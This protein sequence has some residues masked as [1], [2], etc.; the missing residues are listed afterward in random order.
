MSK[1][2][3]I[4]I[5][6][7]KS[8]GPGIITAALVFGPSK[9]TIT[10][11]L[12]ALYGYSTLWLVVVAIFFMLVFTDMGARIGLSSQ[13]TL[14]SQ[15]RKKWGRTVGVIIGMGV[16]LVTTSFQAGNSIGVGIA[17]AEATGTSSWV[18][19]LV[20]NLL[21][22]S[23]LFF[24]S[25]YKTLEKLM[26]GLVGL[27]LL[28]FLTTVVMIKPDFAA[29]GSGLVPNVP[30]GSEAIMIAF[31]A[32]CFSIV[33]AFYQTYL[34]QERNKSKGG[35]TDKN[36]SITG[37]V[38][39]GLMSAVVII[40]AAAV[41]YPQGIQVN[42]ASEM[43]KALEPLFG[44]AAAYLFLAGL[45]GASFSSLIG[46]ATVGGSLLGD[47]VGFGSGLSSGKVRG[48]I[49]LVMVCGAGISLAFG[50]LP[51]E[52]IIFAQSVTIFLV[53]FIGGAMYV[54]A[55]D[56]KMMG[57]RVNNPFVKV[58]GAVGLLLLIA[59][60]SWNFKALFMN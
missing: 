9:M 3:E 32:S 54:V 29:I 57:D 55:N 24:R 11:K 51:L 56:K 50:K 17:V 30:I 7:L 15:I 42:S 18:W 34:V 14:L 27:M 22:M 23:L 45:F 33:G 10:S 31:V 44:S 35:N 38:L 60:A 41:L 26:I 47:A 52:L 40:C 37:I 58:S 20:F 43:S 36:T 48:L 46:N 16:F 49:A 21:G 59:L 19:V 8:L 4:I 1:Q 6:R 5:S 25:F 53:P 28:S 13:E 12:G 2:V 39:L